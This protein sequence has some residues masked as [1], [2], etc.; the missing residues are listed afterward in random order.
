ME[1]L[2]TVSCDVHNFSDLDHS[3][4]FDGVA[5]EMEAGEV[6]Y[7]VPSEVARNIEDNQGHYGIA[8]VVHEPGATD[9]EKKLNVDRARLTALTRMLN[10][11]IEMQTL[12]QATINDHGDRTAVHPAHDHRERFAKR[13]AEVEA[14]IAKAPKVKEAAPEKGKKL[15]NP[16][17]KPKAKARGKKL[18]D[19]PAASSSAPVSP[20]D[21]ADAAAFA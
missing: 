9:K 17:A 20:T 14:L 13:R 6:A 19:L 21:A 16:A 15:G 7:S 4:R 18:G 2:S 10:K 1:G 8:C 3:F 11:Q 5:Y 12:A